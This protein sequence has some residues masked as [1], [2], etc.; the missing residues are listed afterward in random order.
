MP[1]MAPVCPG[2]PVSSNDSKVPARITGAATSAAQNSAANREPGRG[3]DG[4]LSAGG[5]RIAAAHDAGKV[6]GAC[7]GPGADA[8]RLIGTGSGGGA[9]L[10]AV[11]SD[12][13]ALAESFAAALAACPLPE[14]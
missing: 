10:V 6:A 14:R 13:R 8:A 9:D 5:P 12:V 3:S 11:G 1:A 7:A 4:A 2:T